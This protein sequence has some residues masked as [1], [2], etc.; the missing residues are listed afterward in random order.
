VRLSR[1]FLSLYLLAAAVSFAQINVPQWTVHELTLRASGRYSHLY[2]DASVTATFRGPGGASKTVPGFWD[3]GST[4]KIRFAPTIPGRWS[5][6]TTSSDPGLG[7][8]SGTIQCTRP[9]PRKHGFLRR[10]STHPYSFVWDDGSRYFMWGQT[11][12]DVLLNVMAHGRWKKGVDNS[13]AHHMNKIR[14][15]VFAQKN[16]KPGVEETTYPQVIPYGGTFS[17]PDREQ[18][19]IAYWRSLDE[20]VKYLDSRGMIADLII[21]NPYG[22]NI[23]W[24]TEPQDERYLRYVLARYAAFPHVIWCL[25][26]EWNYTKKPQAYFNTMGNIIRQEDPWMSDGDRLRALSIHQGTRIDFN[27]S[28]A[29][30]PVHAIIQYGVRNEETGAAGESANGSRTKYPNGD[31]WGNAGILYNLGHEMPVVNDE[32]GYIGENSPV[33]LTRTQHRRAIWS[34]AAA[35][36]YGSVGDF[37][38]EASGN[39]EISGDW[40]AA[41][42]YGDIQR[43]VDFFTTR[44]IE[45][46]KM[47]SHNS[48][49]TSGERVYVLAESG[50]QYLIY[51]AVGGDFSVNIGPGTYAARRYDPRSGKDEALPQVSGGGSRS[52]QMPDTND[53]VLYLIEKAASGARE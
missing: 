15:H 7:G 24:G 28:G 25:C 34:I 17:N 46:W 9:P 13:A 53:W 36:G 32:Y 5:W 47:S 20:Y 33:N 26:N 23:M 51:A 42:E 44:G 50:R 43:L 3:G 49:L 38:M 18:L 8:R 29:N 2:T 11:Y 31:Q 10:D 35:G 22:D 48:L 40:A 6:A 52:F 1:P 19:N 41:P 39:P 21:F 4:F 37:R 45:Y 30:W 12:Y 27:Y 16:Y 14:L